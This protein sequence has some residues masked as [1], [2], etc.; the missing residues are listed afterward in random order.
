MLNPDD[1]DVSFVPPAGL[2]RI[3]DQGLVDLTPWHI[4]PRDWARI[5]L[6]GLR[7]RYAALGGP[8]LRR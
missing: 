5:R 2:S 4:M 6:K 3:V 7:E 8:R 1:V